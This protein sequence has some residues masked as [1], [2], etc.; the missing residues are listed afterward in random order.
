MPVNDL[1]EEKPLPFCFRH[2][3]RYVIHD[4]MMLAVFTMITWSR[5]TNRYETIQHILPMIVAT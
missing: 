5:K 3:V 1:D 2:A 4:N